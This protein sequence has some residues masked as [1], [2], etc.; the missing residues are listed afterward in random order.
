MR[1]AD[2]GG[3]GGSAGQEAK[4]DCT[5]GA[6]KTRPDIKIQP[7]KEGTVIDHIPAGLALTVLSI[8]G[9]TGQGGSVVSVAINVHSKESGEPK[10][11]VKIENRELDKSE[12]DKIALIAPNA[13]INIIRDFEVAEKYRVKLPDILEGVLECPNPNCISNQKEPVQGRAM[14]D[15]HDPLVVKCHYCG[16]RHTDFIKELRY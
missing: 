9:I 14:V 1:S 3:A 2:G 5:E 16:K 12:I 7:I 11:I 6:A 8:L 15:S 4:G 10:D 13:T